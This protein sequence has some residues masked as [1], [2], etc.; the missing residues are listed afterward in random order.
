MSTSGLI[1]IL[2]T[3]LVGSTELASDLGDVAADEM[4][5]DHFAS[6]REAIAAT[7]GTEVKTIGDALMVSYPG[8]ADALGGAAT[9]QRAVERHNRKLGEGRLAMRVGISAGDASFEDG[10]WFG[11]P[12]VESS[13]LCAAAQGGQILVSDIVRVLAGSRTELELRSLGELDLKGLPAPLGACEV[14]WQ[15]ATTGDAEIPLPVCIDTD[16]SFP[17]AGRAE[18]VENLVAAWKETFEGA[19][20]AVLVSG[21]PGIG[22]TRIVTEV[23]RIAHERGAIVLWGRCDEELGAPYAPFAEALRIY[24]A[25]SPPDR[26]RAELGPLG[27]ELVRIVPELAARVPGLAE[28]VRA[29]ADTERF[30]L[31][32]SVAD[33]LGDISA[34]HPVV[35]VLDDVHWADK[36]SLVLLRHLLRSTTPMRLFVLATYRDTDLDRSHPLAEVLADLRR[37]PGVE[38]LDLQGLDEDEI[39]G[40][41]TKTAGH[42]LDAP[43]LELAHML[44]TETEGNPFFVSE[45]LRHLVESGAIVQHDGRWT[46]GLEGIGIPEGIREVIGRRLSRLSED[47]N[48]A[49]AVAAVIGPT[50]D[51]ATVEAAGG[52]GGDALFDALD[53]AVQHSLIREVRGTAGRY[54]FA[55]ALMRSALYEEITT[56]RKVRMHW[57]V[58]EVL[59]S[60]FASSTDAHLDELAYHFGEGALAGDPMKAVDY[61]RRAGER[62]MDDLAFEAA[63]V[64]FER[65]LGSLDLVDDATREF[66]CD[67]LLAFA[68]TLHVAGDERRRAAVF[69]AAQAARVMGDSGRLARAALVLVSTVSGATRISV[70]DELV[71]LLDEAL[72]ALPPEPSSLRAQL[73]A[74]LAVELQWGP[75]RERRVALANEALG[76]ARA[77]RDPETLGYVLVR[78]WAGMDGSRPWH[79]AFLANME[80]LEAVAVE[81]DDL[82][83]LREVHHY[84]MWI[85]AMV[86]DRPETERRFD[87]YVR[88]ADQLRVPAMS[89]LRLFNEAGIAEYSGRLADAERLTIEGMQLAERADLSDEVVRAF[90]GGLFYYIRF[91]QGRPDELV[92]TLEGLVESQPGAPVWRVALAGVLVESDRIE[93]ARAHFMW[94][95]ENDCAKV[96]CDVEYAV[97][98]DGLARMAYLVRPPDTVLRSIYDRLLPFTGF[99]NWSG[100]GISG[101]NDLGL[102]MTS[103]ALGRHD[104]ADR[105]FAATL[106][107][108]ENAQARCWM[109]RTHFDWSRVLADRGD[110]QTAREHAGI[111][112]V[113]GEE[114]GMDGPFGVVLR[115]RALLESLA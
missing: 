111:A 17:F 109:A 89:A 76:M 39:A 88:L 57:K 98:L 103:A 56:N 62:A 74:S 97:T 102:A 96:P 81:S 5:R 66:R 1:T 110:A 26:V 44:H 85:A 13:R 100:A 106:A 42:D 86:G 15:V 82:R 12:V 60:R 61:A 2:F 99:M 38:R 29:D 25:A 9:M 67:L 91:D 58:G 24:I 32:E 63:A 3:D 4:R 52:P 59:E 79:D 115:G 27:G 21:E 55:H 36:P 65:A 105:H 47:V 22:K 10:D 108:C 112:V 84:A 72:A 20:R 7:G 94:L 69:D 34:A 80:E 92:S 83:A 35:L 31:F 49:L 37:E 70:D 19:R 53:E 40:L 30:R 8:A 95:A 71:A 113:L 28:P 46:A 33:L 114:I 45:V 78:S 68:H 23:V 43:G 77:T 64:H 16:P 73:L 90:G 11:T 107:L 93:D 48:R 75:A 6:L 101:P 18:H 50:F 14:L 51:L 54:A 104:D 41:M 87:A